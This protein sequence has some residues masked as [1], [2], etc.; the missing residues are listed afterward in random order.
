MTLDLWKEKIAFMD[1]DWIAKADATGLD[2]AALLEDFK[3]TVAK[4][5][6]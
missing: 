2:G 4:F 3:A 5:S 6:K 1:A